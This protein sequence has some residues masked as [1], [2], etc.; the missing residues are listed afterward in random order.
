M[1]WKYDIDVDCANCAREVEEAISKVEGV[2]QCTIDYPKK[3]M[4]IEARASSEEEFDVIESMCQKVALETEPDFEMD[5][6][7]HHGHGHEC[8][9][10]DHDCH[11]HDQDHGEC[12]CHGHHEHDTRERRTWIPD[13]KLRLI[14]GLILLFFVNKKPHRNPFILV[15]SCGNSGAE[16]KAMQFLGER[17]ERCVVKSKSAQSGLIELNLEVRL[18]DDNTDFVNSLCELEGVESAVLV[19]YNGDYMG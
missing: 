16:N 17:V 1:R 3:T 10:H 13:L 15:L 18:K 6:H 9:C 8:C 12:H 4:V 11:G 14:I 7:D 19:S 2:V 5:T